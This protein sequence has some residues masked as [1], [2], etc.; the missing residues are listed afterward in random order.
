MLVFTAFAEAIQP[1]ATPLE[2]VFRQ[3]GVVLEGS[4]PMKDR[5]AIWTEFQEDPNVRFFVLTIGTG[6]AG[7]NLSAASVV[8]HYDRWWNPA[9]ERQAT[10]RA[11]RFGQKHDV[12]V[13]RFISKG[14]VE[15]RM[16]EL[17]TS[18]QALFEEL[19]EVDDPV[20]IT[21]MNDEEILALVSLDL[22]QVSKDKDN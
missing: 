3:R 22:R 6:G 1:L 21:E 12:D 10:D 9:K 17:I 16:H 2:R 7:L 15:E 19:F 13:Y 8:V 4:I 14:T 20:R 18:K 11:H 5:A